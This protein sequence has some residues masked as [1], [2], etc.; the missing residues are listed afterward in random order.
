MSLTN[1]EDGRLITSINRTNSCDINSIFLI[2]A[3]GACKTVTM[4]TIRKE[5]L[6]THNF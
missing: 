3:D 4:Q 1:L 6:K 5:L 2:V